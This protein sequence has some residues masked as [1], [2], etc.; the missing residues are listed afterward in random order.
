MAKATV[1][2]LPPLRR[3]SADEGFVALMIAAMEANEHSAPEEARR[4]QHFV[5]SMP[6]FRTRDAAVGRLIFDMKQIRREHAAD[7]IIAAACRAIPPRLRRSALAMV[8][9]IILADGRLQGIERRFLSSVAKQLDQTPADTKAIL[10][11][12]RI[13]RGA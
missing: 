7:A 5:R 8:A 9:D 2:T 6:R 4:A 12:I 13:R 1:A 3:L 10:D 11:T